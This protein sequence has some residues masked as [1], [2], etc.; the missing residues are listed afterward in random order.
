MQHLH[1]AP[2]PV[3]MDHYLF[4]PPHCARINALLP[5]TR[6]FV[7]VFFPQLHQENAA[8]RSGKCVTNGQVKVMFT[9]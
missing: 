6:Y 5:A 2:A 3:E 9:E 8:M 7:V 4:D 1:F